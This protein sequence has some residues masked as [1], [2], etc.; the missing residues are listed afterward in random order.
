MC[1]IFGIYGHKDAARLTYLGLY[2]LQHRGEESAGIVVSSEKKIMSHKGMGLVGDV[3]DEKSIKSLRGDVAIGHVRYSTTGSSISK[4][5]Q[6]FSVNHS[7]G[8]IAIAHNG[9]LTNAFKL[10]H[11][12]EGRGS[13][14]QTTMDSETIVHLLAKS[15]SPDHRQNLVD[16]LSGLE[17][18]YSLVLMLNGYLAGARDPGGW[19]PLCIGKLDDAYVLASE[20]C[21]LDLINAEYIREVEPGEIVF[22][23]KKGIESQKP[24]SGKK[25]SFCIFEYI[26]FARPDSN[27]FGQNVYLTRKRLGKQL[28]KE[29]PA[30]GDFVMPVPDS[31][32]YAAL[33]F[34]EESGIP[35][36]A[37]L[38]RNHY[39]GRTFIQ[40]SQFIRDFRV[41][42]KLNPIKDVLRNKRTVI[43][44]DSI[45]R[46]TTSRVRVKTLREAGAK[47][48]HMRVSCPPL[49]FPCFYGI[50]F[51]TK[52]ELI[53]SNHSIK[54]IKD[55]IGLDSLEYLSK[56]GMLK[57]MPI[58]KEEFC[59]ACFDGNYPAKPCGRMSKCILEK[60]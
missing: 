6:P 13:I 7:K 2:A 18:A 33:G 16:A 39:V 35:Y 25:H 22:I 38:I 30:K 58:P 57:S 41:R 53:A 50:D 55:F 28:A 24:F 51:P 60:K 15:Q 12:M 34:S 14:F 4:N 59:T 29:F 37:A 40:P 36:E 47:E 44:E 43:I 10:R 32:N 54:W 49:R 11:D 56:E 1:G 45:V 52:K 42:V 8:H 5:I 9:N 21:A 31:G 27:I 3:F 23:S 19:R 48:V 20:T 26:Y 46:G 17:G